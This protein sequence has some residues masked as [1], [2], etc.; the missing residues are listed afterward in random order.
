LPGQIEQPFAHGFWMLSLGQLLIPSR[1]GPVMFDQF[2]A[3]HR[4]WI[5]QERGWHGLKHPG[6]AILGLD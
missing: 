2:L 4:Y 3:G 1:L 6:T 5:A